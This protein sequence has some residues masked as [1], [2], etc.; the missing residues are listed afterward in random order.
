MHTVTSFDAGWY[1]SIYNLHDTPNTIH[2][3]YS[4]ILQDMRNMSAFLD[5]KLNF[6]F[7]DILVESQIFFINKGYIFFSNKSHS[8]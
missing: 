1:S 3:N 5:W 4:Q 8:I 2:K 7:I 6:R